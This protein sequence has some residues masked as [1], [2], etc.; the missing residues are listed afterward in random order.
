[1]GQRNVH[2]R[3]LERKKQREKK[4]YKPADL[5]GDRVAT[6]SYWVRRDVSTVKLDALFV[7]YFPRQ[8]N[9]VKD[10]PLPQMN[11][12]LSVILMLL[13]FFVACT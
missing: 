12:F 7:P 10:I 13:L 5:A 11:V 8:C 3:K 9:F 4:R 1:M 6:E 2:C